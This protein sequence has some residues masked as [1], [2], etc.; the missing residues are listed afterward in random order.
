MAAMSPA[1]NLPERSRALGVLATLMLASAAAAHA[2]TALQLQ[3][4]T[5]PLVALPQEL[6]F[7]WEFQVNVP[8]QLDHFGLFDAGPL[9][10]TH[11]WKIKIWNLDGYSANADEI[12]LPSVTENGFSY[13]ESIVQSGPEGIVYG[14]ILPVGRYAIAAGLLEFGGNDDLMPSQAANIVTDPAITF[15]QARS[16][17]N[18][19]HDED[20]LFPENVEP[21]LKNLGPNFQY[22]VVPEPATSGLLATT[23]A[24]L[25]TRRRRPPAKR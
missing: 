2:N 18:T 16:A 21:G 4:G 14:P 10:F 25:T 3:L 20:L 9:G 7:G 19:G 5:N 24:L 22:T 17:L 15:I 12:R 23:L 8:I 6:V 13:V 11:E 1:Q